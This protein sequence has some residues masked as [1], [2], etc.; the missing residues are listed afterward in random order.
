MTSDLTTSR[1]HDSGHLAAR[2][3]L[4]GAIL[5]MVAGLVQMTVGTRIP[6]WTGA[7]DDPVA[8]GALTV[9]LSAIA[10]VAASR[11]RTPEQLTAQR[12]VAVVVAFIIPAVLCFTTVGRLWYI[13]AALL[14]AACALTAAAVDTR[15]LFTVVRRNR[16]RWLVSTLG[17]FVVL[18]AVSAAAALTL[19]LGVVGGLAVMVAPWLH[20]RTKPVVVV[21]MLMAALP[22]AVITW[23]SIASPLVAV[24][25][26]IIGITAIRGNTHAEQAILTTPRTLT[27]TR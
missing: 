24:L 26:V 2:L 5:G 17:A 20:R 27:G 13:P 18:M 14:L 23:W 22:F 16:T 15:D 8:L 3:G 12:R 10:A 21:T 9:V 7:K 11:L 6:E 19:V 4:V 25:A 1:A